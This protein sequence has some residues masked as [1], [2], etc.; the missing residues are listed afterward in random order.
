VIWVYEGQR[1]WFPHEEVQQGDACKVRKLVQ[2]TV[3]VSMG[4]KARVV[5]DAYGIDSWADVDELEE[6]EERYGTEA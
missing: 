2:C 6:V 5:N 3:A 4:D 1:V